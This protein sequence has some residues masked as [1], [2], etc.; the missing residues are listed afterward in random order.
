MRNLY[1]IKRDNLAETARNLANKT[2][3]EY[4]VYRN[5]ERDRVEI[6]VRADLKPEDKILDT[7][8]GRV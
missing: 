7:F 4:L 3:T 6:G 1:E 5:A 8:S 2:G